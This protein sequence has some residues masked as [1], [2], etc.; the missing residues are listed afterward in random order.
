VGGESGAT[1]HTF[2]QTITCL[3]KKGTDA[4][5]ATLDI[6]GK[7]WYGRTGALVEGSGTYLAIH[8]TLT[9]V[10]LFQF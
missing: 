3:E 8:F 7:T 1:V 6:A 10:F 9:I 4:F 5:L 2:G